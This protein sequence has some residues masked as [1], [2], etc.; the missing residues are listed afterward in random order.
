[1][2]SGALATKRLIPTL[3][4]AGP[5]PQ[6]FDLEIALDQ[7]DSRLKPGMTAQITV[8][9]DRVPDAIT[10]PAQGRGPS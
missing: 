1:L 4:L 2:K 10:I 6:N 7:T 5:I 9:V 8:I 3:S